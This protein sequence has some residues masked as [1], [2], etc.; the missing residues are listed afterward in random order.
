[1]DYSKRKLV[2][3]TTTS[4][5]TPILVEEDN[6]TSTFV[7]LERPLGR[8]AEKEQ[9]KKKKGKDQIYDNMTTPT[10]VLL[11]KYI[12]EKKEMESKRMDYYSRARK[13]HH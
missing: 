4:P 9:L 1:M 13:D 2:L 6:L 10:S 7:D 3:A 11:E 12:E 8:K 5:S